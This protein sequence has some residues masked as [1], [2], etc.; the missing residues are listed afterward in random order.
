M[1]SLHTDPNLFKQVRPCTI[2]PRNTNLWIIF[3]NMIH[4]LVLR[5]IIVHWRTKTENNGP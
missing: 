1:H 4:K 5:G 2:M 3:A